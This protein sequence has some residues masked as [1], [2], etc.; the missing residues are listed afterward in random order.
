MHPLSVDEASRPSAQIS[1]IDH[2]DANYVPQSV[3]SAVAARGR[4]PKLAAGPTPFR[5]SKRATSDA[6]DIHVPLSAQNH[7]HWCRVKVVWSLLVSC[8]GATARRAQGW[9]RFALPTRSSLAGQVPPYSLKVQAL[10]HL[11]GT[12]LARGGPRSELLGAGDD[13][14]LQHL[15]SILI[16]RVSLEPSSQ[17]GPTL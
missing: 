14:G 2:A 9:L 8:A 6:A 7:H 11:F 16:R 5:D 13:S 1:R 17:C 3:V 4:L 15:T 12:V 10:P